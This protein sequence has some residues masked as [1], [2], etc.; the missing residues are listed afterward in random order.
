MRFWLSRKR[1]ASLAMR[2]QD[3]ATLNQAG[4]DVN[5]SISQMADPA[6]IKATVLS[7]I[8]EYDNNVIREREETQKKMVGFLVESF[9]DRQV[10]LSQLSIPEKNAIFLNAV[11]Q[12]A[13]GGDVTTAQ[14]L[15]DLVV[16]A[17]DS[18]TKSFLSCVVSDAVPIV[19]RLPKAHLSTLAVLFA[20]QGYAGIRQY[21]TIEGALQD[22]SEGLPELINDL[23][24][25]DAA[26][27]HLGSLGLV[28]IVPIPLPIAGS[29]TKSWPG[30][31]TRGFML[32]EMKPPLTEF[33][34]EYLLAPH[35]IFDDKF[36]V[37]KGYE[38]WSVDDAF[39][40]WS[41][42]VAAE[43]KRLVD[44]HRMTDEEASVQ[45]LKAGP[46]MASLLVLEGSA[47][48]MA[49]LTPLGK[50][51]GHARL[52]AARTSPMPT[53]DYWIDDE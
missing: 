48:G 26:I 32:D 52:Q 53:L 50:A 46:C 22:W 31:F 20:I 41:Q 30:L 9:H 29:F 13:A 35:P 12:Q 21:S 24:R 23:T 17:A 6:T 40:P 47:F 19:P 43:L 8:Y 16:T 34:A 51:I 37:R 42:A 28:T 2:G 36:V 7:M 39:P 44:L 27:L 25:R 15:T 11:Q 38:Y 14:M 1:D 49:V 3:G 10:P 18:A 4:R 45:L 5:V 33:S